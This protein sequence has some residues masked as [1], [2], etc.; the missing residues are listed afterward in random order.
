MIKR[1]DIWDILSKNYVILQFRRVCVLYSNNNHFINSSNTFN[2][3]TFVWCHILMWCFLATCRCYVY[4]YIIYVYTHYIC[5][6]TMEY[7]SITNIPSEHFC[8]TV[9]INKQNIIS[10]GQWWS[11]NGKQSLFN[12]ISI[13]IIALL[14]VWYCTILTG[15]CFYLQHVYRISTEWEERKR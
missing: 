7:A 14:T 13:V 10:N 2:W 9:V 3:I 4:I 1:V 8:P 12:V 15:I 5:V 11:C 6:Y